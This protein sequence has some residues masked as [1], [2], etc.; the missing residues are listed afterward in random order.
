MTP[1]ESHIDNPWQLIH[2]GKAREAVVLLQERY[3]QKSTPRTSIALGTGLMWA[4][5]YVA[6]REHFRSSIEEAK[7]QRMSSEEDFA[8]LGTAEWCLD[9]DSVAVECWRSGMA[10]KYA[11]LGVCIHSPMMLFIASILRPEL[12]LKSKAILDELRERLADPRTKSWPGT[13]AQFVAGLTTIEAVQSSWIG[14]RDQNARR[15]FPDC[16]WITE[17]Y[18][19]LLQFHEGRTTLQRFKQTIVSLTAPDQYS[20]WEEDD[21]VNLMRFPEFYI[22]RHESHSRTG[23]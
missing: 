15:V 9:N 13:L 10:A 6:A 17:F 2:A 18:G 4:G 3:E 19:E 23:A 8:F 16:R 20:S 12:Q 21:F 14:N 22:A 11:I 7:R 5:E 1:Q